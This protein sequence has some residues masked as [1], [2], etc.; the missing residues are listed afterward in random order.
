MADSPLVNKALEEAGSDRIELRARQAGKSMLSAAKK[1][2]FTLS[3][4]LDN[5][6]AEQ[7]EKLSSARG[8]EQL[9]WWIDLASSVGLVATGLKAD[10]SDIMPGDLLIGPEDWPQDLCYWTPDG[11]NAYI[12]H[13]GNVS[14]F[15]DS[16]QL[17]E[18]FTGWID[19][20]FI[21]IR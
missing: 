14:D 9:K 18:L 3:Q 11:K 12:V 5:C 21:A 20:D 13:M 19:N 8:E 16:I 7:D 6:T 2:F 1:K 15:G 10:Y 17:K 4:A